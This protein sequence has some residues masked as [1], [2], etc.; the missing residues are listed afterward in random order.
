MDKS[1]TVVP[2]AEPSAE[3]ASEAMPR[4]G[5]GNDGAVERPSGILRCAF[6][7][8]ASWWVRRGFVRRRRRVLPETAAG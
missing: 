6:C 1:E 7:G 8:R 4:E 5:S 2:R 3:E